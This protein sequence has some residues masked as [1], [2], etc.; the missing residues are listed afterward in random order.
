MSAPSAVPPLSRRLP[1][2]G[3]ALLWTVS[4]VGSGSVLFTPRVAARYEYALLWVALLTCAFMWIMIR[5]AARYT[6]V[7]GQT[8]FDGFNRLGGPRG[9]ALWVIFLPQLVAAVVGIAVLCALVGSAA[10]VALGGSHAAY[11]LAMIGG[12]ATLV[13]L[14]EYDAVERASRYM[15]VLL[16]VLSSAA[17]VQVMPA[18][19]VIASG[20]VPKLPADFD[21]AFVLPWIGTI[22]AGSMG[23]VWFAYWTATHGY[24]GTTVLSAEHHERASAPADVDGTGPVRRVTAWVG[25]VSQAAA[26][27]VVA[28]A[29]VIVA[30]YILGA[31]LLAPRGLIPAGMDVASDLATLLEAVWGSF[32]FWSLIVLTLF[33]L[34][35]SVIANQDGWSRSFADI[36]LLLWGDRERPLWMTRRRLKH[37]YTVTV[38]ALLPA[39]TYLAVEDPV[40]IMSISGVVAAVHTPFIVLLILLVNRIRLP[41]EL[42]PGM[43]ACTALAAAGCYYLGVAVLRFTL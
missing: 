33:A 36:S 2:Y 7:T 14:G 37:F 41:R 42:R 31:E 9:W 1:W 16:V 3:P 10:Q 20:L 19:D 26:V 15:A 34:G 40:E 38:T 35:G 43:L 32:G 8:L 28:G 22:L 12:A 5:E 6:T 25:V 24:G 11:T 30:F 39:L 18:P 23:I 29:W 17:A 27:A 21:L 4:A 13:M